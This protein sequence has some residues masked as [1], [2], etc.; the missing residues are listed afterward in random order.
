MATLQ[1]S[2]IQ[3]RRGLHQDL[4]ILHEGELGY[5][6][7]RKRL[8]IG[9]AKDTFTGDGNTTQFTLTSKIARP[10]QQI[11]VYV[12]DSRKV[13]D[14]DYSVSG[15]TLTFLGS[16]PALSDAI[17][18]GYNTE[19]EIHNTELVVDELALGANQ[20]DQPTG[21]FFNKHIFNTA[22]IEYSI[23]DAS[24][25]YVVGQLRMITDYTTV[26]VFDSFTQTAS[27]GITFSG[28]INGDNIVLRYSNSSS[29]TAKFYYN[30]KLWNTI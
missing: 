4:P 5:A 12:N 9:N 24:G 30:V 7:D 13:P 16:A 18:V 21:F 10:T 23:R 11:L 26:Q 19:L 20:T 29:A 15:T 22:I 3:H 25:N 6:T 8:Y 1:I 2:R 28:A 27:L 17:E 14:I